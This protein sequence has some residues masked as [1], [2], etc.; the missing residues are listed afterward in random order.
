MSSHHTPTTFNPAAGLAALILPG[1]GHFLLGER[2]RALAIAAGVLGLF[3]GGLFIGGID[4]V[5]SREDRLWFI[6]QA[7]VGP[8]AFGVDYIHQH[9]FKGVGIPPE[10]LLNKKI[11]WRQFDQLTRHTRSAFPGEVREVITLQIPDAPAGQPATVSVPVLR[12]LSP[13]EFARAG[14]PTDVAAGDSP[15]TTEHLRALDAQGLGP[16]NRKSLS[17]VNELGTLFS[18]IAGMLNLI[19]ILDAFF[20]PVRAAR[21]TRSPETAPETAAATAPGVAS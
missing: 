18:T 6:G 9:H 7:L 16:P 14:I 8:V 10:I 3:F 12:R 5:D 13:D 4:S 11:S 1:A 21:G 17:K 19:V 20:P 2:S 15:L